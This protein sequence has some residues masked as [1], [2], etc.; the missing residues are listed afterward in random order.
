MRTKTGVAALALSTFIT[1]AWAENTCVRPED[2]AALQ[3]A[4]VQQRFMV[5]ALSCNSVELYNN[6]VKAYRGDLQKSDEALQSYFLRRNTSTGITDYH[7]YKTKLAN[8]YST[9]S[10]TNLKAFCSNANAFFGT[11]LKEKQ[12]LADVVSLQPVSLEANDK[13]CGGGV[14]GG[15]MAVRGSA[16]TKPVQAK[17]AEPP[18]TAET[19][20][21]AS[22]SIAPAITGRVPNPI[23][24]TQKKPGAQEA[25]SN[26]GGT[27]TQP[28][29]NA[30]Q[31][32]NRN[33][34]AFAGPPPY[35]PPAR[36]RPRADDPRF[37]RRANDQRYARG[38]YDGPGY[39]YRPTY[40]YG[41]G[42]YD[43]RYDNPASARN[44]YPYPSG[45]YYAP[46]SYYGPNTY[47]GAPYD[48]F[49]P[50]GEPPQYFPGRMR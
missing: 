12:T 28:A 50:N 41:P 48:R 21:A 32:F 35:Q 18:T 24:S 1:T 39:S 6:F 25:A 8:I 4:A 15:A 47:Y 10:A 30:Q 34:D 38:P 23:A 16:E 46:D 49:Y 27:E 13:S 19:A 45:G 42:G 43:S 33:D 37:A 40:P 20:A 9:R 7:A 11:A 26:V 44:R 14:A 22:A 36:L 3:V 17:F 2:M 29:P 5:A 31:T